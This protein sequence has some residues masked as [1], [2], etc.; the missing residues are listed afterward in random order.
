MEPSD[1]RAW[2]KEFKDK[3][4]LPKF[5]FQDIWCT[6]HV[7]IQHCDNVFFSEQELSALYREQR[8]VSCV[9]RHRLL[10]VHSGLNTRNS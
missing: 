5:L 7:N 6:I 8:S 4:S 3:M 2:W 9:L 10:L 1:P